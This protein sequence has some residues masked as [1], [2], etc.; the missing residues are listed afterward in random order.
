MSNVVKTKD[1]LLVEQAWSL[2]INV[3]TLINQRCNRFC[4]KTNVVPIIEKDRLDQLYER[5]HSRYKRRLQKLW[6]QMGCKV[7][8]MS[9]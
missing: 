6:K 2:Q 7:T 8:V 1:R 3:Q 5:A 9:L 4:L